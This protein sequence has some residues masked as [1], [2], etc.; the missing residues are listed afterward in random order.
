MARARASPGRWRSGR[1]LRRGRR[2]RSRGWRVRCGLT[3]MHFALAGAADLVSAVCRNRINQSVTLERMRGRMS[4]VYTLVVTGGPR[5]GEVESGAVAGAA[6]A[7]ISVLSGGVLCVI[8]VAALSSPSPRSSRYD[9]DWSRRRPRLRRGRC[10][11]RPS[12]RA[13]APPHP[14]YHWK[15]PAPTHR[16]IRHPVCAPTIWKRPR[17]GHIACPARRW[18][19]A[20]AAFP[21]RS[22]DTERRAMTTQCPRQLHRQHQTTN[23]YP[24]D[25]HIASTYSLSNPLLNTLT[26]T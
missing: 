15:P 14:T 18:S 10:R 7:R 24:Q 23:H 2:W 21:A 1:S 16:T 6:G 9:A 25:F 11:A 8:G 12:A 26:C 20:S 5:L 22:Q 13:S 19:I 17:A 3:V 4:A